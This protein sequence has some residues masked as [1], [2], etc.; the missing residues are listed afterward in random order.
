EER[1]YNDKAFKIGSGQTISHPSTVAIQT[2]LLQVKKTDKVLEIGTGS[3]YQTAVLCELG[4]KVFS[5]ER[6]KAL[7][8]KTKPLLEE[9]GYRAKLFYGDGY[10]GQHAFAPFDKI[11][12]TCGAPFIPEKLVEQLKPGGLMVIP[13]G[14]KV[15]IMNVLIKNIDN[16][17]TVKEYG[18][19]RFVPMLEKKVR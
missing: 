9:M 10:A 13:L 11:I 14:E 7:Y 6:Q 5:I 12:I 4:C 2:T 8:D 18:E 19:F 1:A 3:G 16:Q 17:I 15:Q